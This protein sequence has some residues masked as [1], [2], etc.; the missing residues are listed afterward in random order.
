MPATRLVP[1]ELAAELYDEL[2]R[3]RAARALNPN[4]GTRAG[5]PRCPDTCQICLSEVVLDH[6]LNQIPRGVE[7]CHLT[8][9]TMPLK[10]PTVPHDICGKGC[11][12]SFHPEVGGPSTRSSAI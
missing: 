10:P 8:V 11:T 12:D 2:T 1:E 5:A 7:E 9:S 3:L 6:L 4:H